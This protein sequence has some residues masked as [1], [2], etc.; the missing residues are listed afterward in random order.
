MLEFYPVM[1]SDHKVNLR[2]TTSARLNEE[3]F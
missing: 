3:T 1:L 2:F